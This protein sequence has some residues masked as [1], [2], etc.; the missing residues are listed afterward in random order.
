MNPVINSAARQ[1]TN[2]LFGVF[3][4][5]SVRVFVFSCEKNIIQ[6]WL[7]SD[8]MVAPFLHVHPLYRLMI[9]AGGLK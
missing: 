3:S 6:R 9:N 4:Q 5:G 1:I 8:M 2:M 7:H